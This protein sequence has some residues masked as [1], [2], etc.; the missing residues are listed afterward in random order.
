MH[1]PHD[2]FTISW[3]VIVI[4]E[5]ACF[6]LMVP[7]Y[8]NVVTRFELKDSFPLSS[9]SQKLA[10]S[11]RAG[12]GWKANWDEE[13]SSLLFRNKLGLF[14][15]PRFLGRVD[16]SQSSRRIMWSPPLPLTTGALVIWILSL[17]W[18]GDV[19]PDEKSFIILVL[20]TLAIITFAFVVSYGVTIYFVRAMIDDVRH[21]IS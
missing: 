2:L 19:F 1:P 3:I 20:Y 4:V 16:M 8:Y 10:R 21:C 5:N 17:L 14:V 12:D 18:G 7:T 15:K 9:T 13:S 11:I 6:I